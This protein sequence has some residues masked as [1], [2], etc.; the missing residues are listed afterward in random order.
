M[1]HIK[2][3]EIFETRTLGTREKYL[4][5]LIDENGI[6]HKR[7]GFIIN[8]KRK[9]NLVE[10]IVDSE[11]SYEV[12]D[13]NKDKEISPNRIHEYIAGIDINGYII[14]FNFDERTDQLKNIVQ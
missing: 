14:G 6:L 4:N 3:Y 10:L 2:K 8:V 5:A 13:V 7:K 9:G 11:W 1:K 12:D